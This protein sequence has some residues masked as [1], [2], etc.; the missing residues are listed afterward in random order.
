M[1]RAARE[2]GRGFEFGAWRVE[3]ASNCVHRK[4]VRRQL[5]PRAMDVLTFLCRHEGEVVPAE[6]IL[7]ACWGSTLTGDNPVHKILTQL[8]QALDD[9][10]TAP[11]YIETIR[12]RGYRAIAP[13]SVDPP[14]PRWTGGSPFRGLDAFG[15]QHAAIFHGRRRAT[16]QLRETLLRQLEARCPMVAVL[17]P[18]GS[19]K[20]SLVQAGLLAQLHDDPPAGLRLAD[21]LTL[22]C[23]DVGAAGLFDAL[24]SV[25]LDGAVGAV[26]LFPNE[27]AASLGARLR[28]DPPAVAVRLQGRKDGRFALFVDHLEAIYRY[29]HVND[30]ERTAFI[31]VLEHLARSGVLVVLA[32]RNDFYPQVM[33]MPSLA[34]LKARGGH[35]DLAAP[36]PTEI[37][38]IIRQPALAAGLHFETD[39]VSGTG[40]DDVL[41]SAA[42][43]SADVLPLLEYCLHE[44]YRRR[45]AADRMTFEVYHQLGGIE[46]AIGARAEQ[47]VAALS[48]A[49][50]AALPRVLSQLVSIAEDQLAVTARAVPWVTLGIGPERELVKAMVE[51]RLFVSSL[52]SGTAMF[53]IAHEALLRRWPRAQAWI[54]R[55]RQALQV[56]TRA[57]AG[58]SRWDA[59]GRRADLLL[60]AGLQA[61]QAAGLLDMPEFSLQALER[62]FIVASLRR[63]RRGERLR[64]LVS[65]ALFALAVLA[66]G[67]GIAAQG[68][69]DRAELH[70]GQ[71]EALMTYML[72][73]FVD[74]LRPLG[75]LDLLD[76]VSTRALA[77]LSDAAKRHA[78]QVELTQ[79]AK[80][81]Q[82][83]AEVKRARAD[84]AAARQALQ[85]ARAILQRQRSERPDDRAVLVNFGANAFYLGDQ[86]LDEGDL[87][88]A[89]R[90]FTEYRE[91][92]DRVAAL[93]PND[94]AAWIEQAYAA[95]SL[96]SVAL[97]R[98]QVALAAREFAL[99]AQL[100]GRALALKPGDA[101]LQA[102]L[103]DTLSWLATLR[104]RLGELAPAARLYE[105]Q[106]ALLKTVRNAHP[107]DALWSHRYALAL[108]ARAR[109][110]TAL[111]QDEAGRQALAEAADLLRQV[112]REDPT[113]RAW[114]ADRAALQLELAELDAGDPG[115]VAAL[116]A[117]A[118]EIDALVAL[119]PKK[120]YLTALA[121]VARIA[122][123]QAHG[124]AGRTAEAQKALA[125]ATHSLSALAPAA[126]GISEKVV[127][128]WLRAGWLRRSLRDDAGA[129]AACARAR[130]LVAPSIKDSRDYHT[131]SIWV[132]SQHCLGTPGLAHEE[133]ARLMQMGYRA[134]TYRQLLA[135]VSSTAGPTRGDSK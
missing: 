112:V 43:G 33:A 110:L 15:R 106:G 14:Q 10:A 39:P 86:H 34:M 130:D 116:R 64:V 2:L 135:Q 36:G 122:E 128:G 98:D 58:A 57:G 22:D 61:R 133:Q 94:P 109:L 68:A 127:D 97:R 54:E 90:Y 92:S 46:G 123:A 23:G 51:A 80:A 125:P 40:L 126:D 38:Q 87:D 25:L 120:P 83:I 1:Q 66:V 35:F 100:K 113:N 81:L 16:A 121:A 3:P 129:R 59:A 19:G 28:A 104:E 101:T 49:E 84:P 30:D 77:Y 37:A 93:A 32:C 124:R 42:N 111:G 78:S 91:A 115:A 75:R 50:A 18:S 69:R 89:A 73:E 62:D 114:L 6:A 26:P 82:L 7:D 108:W 67:L 52:V 119:E 13:V 74:R 118:R 27:S 29:R 103:A 4:G 47:V 117:V 65:G 79:R 31:E 105:Q 41:C 9:S 12:K 99:S 88:A 53:G 5:E 21:A 55:H 102:D 63:A 56:L 134:T 17:G 72:G 48:Q 131:L 107:G 85:G 44:L 24:G 8:R 96:G 70:R 45:D 20:S 71:A 132:L 60:P 76:T 11:R 95:N